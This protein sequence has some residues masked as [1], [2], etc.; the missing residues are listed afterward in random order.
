MIRAKKPDD[1]ALVAAKREPT[2]RERTVGREAKERDLARRKRPQVEVYGDNKGVPK[3]GP[4]HNDGAL[5]QAALMD[6]F[7]TTSDDF[8]NRAMAQ[9]ATALQRQGTDSIEGLNAGLAVVAG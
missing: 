3:V 7:G 5:F 1:T 4:P 2:E 9:L 8:L 6:A